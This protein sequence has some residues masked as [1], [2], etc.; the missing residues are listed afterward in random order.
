MV[1]LLLVALVISDR[2]NQEACRVFQ[3]SLTVFVV[4]Q[5]VH[6]TVTDTEPWI[7][8]TSWFASLP[9]T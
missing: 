9:L 6:F 1:D 8:F 5:V 3:W 2:R 7:A 4:F